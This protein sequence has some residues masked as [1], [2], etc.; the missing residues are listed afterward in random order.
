MYEIFLLSAMCESL[1]FYSILMDFAEAVL[2]T[3]CLEGL[4]LSLS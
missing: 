4:C 3:P 1:E 2:G